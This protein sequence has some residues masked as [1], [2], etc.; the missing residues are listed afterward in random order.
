MKSNSKEE[1]V[2][3]LSLAEQEALIKEEIQRFLKLAREKGSLTVE[4]INELLPPEII[5]ASVL[6]SFMQALE[7]N[8]VALTDATPARK[9]GDDDSALFS[10]EEENA[11]DE[12][13]E[14][15]LDEE[16]L[17]GN[18]PVRLYLRKMGSVSL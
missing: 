8:G 11:E 12:D 14:E 5:A 13:E 4:E 7:V 18:D 16:D 17:K 2:K 15:A 10:G 3:E 1:S 9:E 6:D